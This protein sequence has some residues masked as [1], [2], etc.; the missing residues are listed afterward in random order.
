[1]AVVGTA[2]ELS[3]KQR[4]GTKTQKGKRVAPILAFLRLCVEFWA[5]DGSPDRSVDGRRMTTA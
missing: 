3:A 5:L 4:K 2:I 1:M